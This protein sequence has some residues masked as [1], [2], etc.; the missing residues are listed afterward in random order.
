MSAYGS[1][2]IGGFILPLTLF[3]PRG[4]HSQSTIDIYEICQDWNITRV[5]N[6]RDLYSDAALWP[7]I[8]KAISLEQYWNRNIKEIRF[9]KICCIK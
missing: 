8:K 4:L 5:G 6:P 9:I 2:V 3:T 1:G 7:L